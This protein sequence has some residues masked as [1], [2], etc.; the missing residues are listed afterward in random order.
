MHDEECFCMLLG[1]DGSEGLDLSFVTHIFFL[2]FLSKD[3]ALQQQA[4]SRAYR[5]GAKGSVYVETLIAENSV[6]ETEL[7]L[8]SGML[9]DGHSN[10]SIA[11]IQTIQSGTLSSKGD[12]EYQRAKLHFL[13]KSLKLI[14][15]SSTSSFGIVKKRTATA[16]TE[17]LD[18]SA[19]NPPM[20]KSRKNT[21]GVDKKL[22][23]HFAENVINS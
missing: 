18:S 13:L 15:N 21:S 12:K 11:E 2:E 10:N 1:K 19:S 17:G 6:E 16:L 4:V 3:K 8:E 9:E 23:V 20:K 22:H 5:M 7:R 14:A